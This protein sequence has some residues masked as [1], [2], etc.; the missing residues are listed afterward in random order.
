MLFNKIGKTILVMLSIA[1]ASN[2]AY[3]FYNKKKRKEAPEI[4]EVIIFTYSETNLRQSKYSRCKISHSMERL[5]HY[6][7]SP[8]TSIDICMYVITNQDLANVVVKLHI[9]GIRVRVIMDADMAFSN[10]SVIKKFTKYKIPVHWKKSTN[11]M[12]HKFCLIDAMDDVDEKSIPLVIA[13]SLNW[14][15]QALNGNWEDIIV[16]SQKDLIR[17]YKTEF[18]RLWLQFKCVVNLT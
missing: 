8:R 13:G 2:F 15:N 4:N 16:T 7:N 1:F 12:H 5:L 18:E 11:L 9:R 10:G 17:Q 3:K 6:L 14:T